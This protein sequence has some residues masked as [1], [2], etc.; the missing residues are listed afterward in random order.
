MTALP[1]EY[2]AIETATRAWVSE[3]TELPLASVVWSGGNVPQLT[4]PFAWIRWLGGPRETAPIAVRDYAATMLSRVTV[5]TAVVDQ[6]Y[7]VRIYEGADP[8]GTDPGLLYSYTALI[9]DDVDAIR[10]ALVTLINAYGWPK[11]SADA[12]TGA[13]LLVGDVTTSRKRFTVEPSADVVVVNLYDG[14]GIL[15]RQDSEITFRVQCET[16]TQAAGTDG[17][18][19]LSRARVDLNTRDRSDTLRAAGLVFR[20]SGA[21]QDVSFVANAAHVY[22]GSQ[23]FVFAVRTQVAETRRFIR[24]VTPTVSL[25]GE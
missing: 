15:T 25:S 5:G 17:S 20:K 4:R 22:R 12:A 13:L 1:I 18:A 16:D 7:S 3:S 11:A 8:D 2:A 6:V 21:S 9:G 10:D 24:L 14:H 23:D 19:L